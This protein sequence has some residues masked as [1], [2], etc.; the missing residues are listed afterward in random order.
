MAKNDKTQTPADDIRGI[1]IDGETVLP[2]DFRAV[3]AKHPGRWP[4]ASGVVCQSCGCQFVSLGNE[5]P[6]CGGRTLKE[7]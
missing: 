4:Y 7:L 5:C 3:S 6:K 1:D 2:A